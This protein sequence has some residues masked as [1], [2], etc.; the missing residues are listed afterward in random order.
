[1]FYDSCDNLSNSRFSAFHSQISRKVLLILFSLTGP[2]LY[3]V[4]PWLPYTITSVL[5]MACAV[6]FIFFSQ[7][8][9]KENDKKIAELLAVQSR[10]AANSEAAEPDAL[11]SL[12]AFRQ[13]SF[14]SRECMARMASVS[15][16]TDVMDQDDLETARDQSLATI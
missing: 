14:A 16:I 2:I 5:C 15:L 1:M 8:Q 6:I 7:K 13:I 3:S 9:Q 4:A 10:R 12:A 11:S